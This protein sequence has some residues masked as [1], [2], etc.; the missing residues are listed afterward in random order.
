M[1]KSGSLM[2]Y[3]AFKFD[4]TSADSTGESTTGVLSSFFLTLTVG[5]Q[6]SPSGA[7]RSVEL[8]FEQ[9]VIDSDRIRRLPQ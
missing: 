1:G 8:N 7:L 9:F 4:F 5:L 6:R 2:I 3:F